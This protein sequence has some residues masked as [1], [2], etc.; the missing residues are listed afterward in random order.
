[1]NTPLEYRCMKAILGVTMMPGSWDKRF[2]NNLP[3]DAEKLTEKQRYWLIKIAH[4]YRRQIRDKD[5][6]RETEA[7]L[8]SNKTPE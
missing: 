8:T 2:R 5:L 6:I 3:T 4:R 1:M 7:W